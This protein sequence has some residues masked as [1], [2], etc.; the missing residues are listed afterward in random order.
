MRHYDL[1]D[2]DAIEAYLAGDISLD[3]EDILYPDIDD[4]RDSPTD[5]FDD[6]WDDDTIDLDDE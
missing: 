5:D 6:E 2:P 3:D 1:R 4:D